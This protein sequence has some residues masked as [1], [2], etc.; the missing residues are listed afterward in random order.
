[1]NTKGK[2]IFKFSISLNFVMFCY[3]IP[4]NV[5]KVPMVMDVCPALRIV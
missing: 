1:M 2:I 3:F 5:P 4:Q